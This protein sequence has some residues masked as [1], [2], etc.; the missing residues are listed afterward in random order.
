MILR[1]LVAG[2]AAG[3]AGV[4]LAVSLPAAPARAAGVAWWLPSSWVT[5]AS[6]T[7]EAARAVLAGVGSFSVDPGSDPVTIGAG[8]TPDGIACGFR[9][10]AL[11]FDPATYRLT[12]TYSRTYSQNCSS[13]TVDGYANFSQYVCGDGT[14]EGAGS[15][16][17]PATTTTAVIQYSA[18][19]GGCSTR[20]GVVGFGSPGQGGF[21]QWN[22]FRYSLAGGLL[23]TVTSVTCRNLSTGVDSVISESSVGASVAPA[24]VCPAGTVP[25]RVVVTSAGSVVSDASI[26]SS[27]LANYGAYMGDPGG[28]EWRSGSQPSDC[29]IQKSADPS[30]VIALSASVCS[31]AHDNGY[32]Q[33]EEQPDCGADVVCSMVQATKDFLGRILNGIAT[34]ANRIAGLVESVRSAIQSAVQTVV[35]TIESVIQSVID[36]IGQVVQAIQDGLQSLLDILGQ[37]LDKLGGDGGGGGGGPEG[38]DVGC[39]HIDNPLNPVE[40][41][42][43]PLA[44]IFVPDMD[45]VGDKLDELKD[46]I[47]DKF[48]PW[49]DA[50]DD[51]AGVFDSSGGSCEGWVFHVP[52]YFAGKT[53]VSTI[54]IGNACEYPVSQY[55]AFSRAASLALLSFGAFAAGFNFLMLGIGYVSPV[56]ARSGAVAEAREQEAVAAQDEARLASARRLHGAPRRGIE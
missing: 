40:W 34:T 53:G 30:M 14:Y 50:Y 48:Q 43:R 42:Y 32:G 25:V 19:Y 45:G 41:V 18:S 37:I 17:V 44:C 51:A 28:W 7:V 31:E 38:G 12:V 46:G 52:A 47:V 3:V 15:H 22:A 2:V 54:E 1:R 33:A 10:T 23:T 35:D 36:A 29:W 5:V 24:P 27:A 20:G 6:G 11:A 21:N 56:V 39:A 49:L 4:V 55:A 13:T 26:T 8:P 16:Y 9:I